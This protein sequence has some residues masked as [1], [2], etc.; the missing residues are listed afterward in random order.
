MI[1]L[2]ADNNISEIQGDTEA[3]NN[4]LDWIDDGLLSL[5]NINT[6]DNNNYDWAD[7]YFRC[8]LA[9]IQAEKSEEITGEEVIQFLKYPNLSVNIS[10]NQ[11]HQLIDYLIF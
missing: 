2:I 4:S 3:I 11:F 7:N 5:H 8:S 6:T 1:E 10:F 9:Y